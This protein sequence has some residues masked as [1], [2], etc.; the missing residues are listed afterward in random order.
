MILDTGTN[1]EMDIEESDKEL[2]NG[3]YGNTGCGVLKRG[4]K[5]RKIFV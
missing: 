2:D 4:C 1:M 3:N 5:I